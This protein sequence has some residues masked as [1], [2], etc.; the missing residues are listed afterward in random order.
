MTYQY[1]Y[2]VIIPHKNRQQ[3]LKRCLDSIPRR[4]NVQIIVVDDKSDPEK[5]DFQHFP[6]LHEKNTEVYFTK[7]GKG[8]GYARNV[9]LDH[10]K[11]KWILFADSDDQYL[12]NLEEEMYNY[13]ESEA[14]M[15]VFRQKRKNADGID[16]EC[17]YDN[18]FD[19]AA[20]GNFDSL[21]SYSCVYG[22]FIKK[23]FLDKYHIRFQEVMYS[24]DVLFS[25]KVS[26]FSNNILFVNKHIYC[27]YES[28][29]SLMR[30]TNWKNPYIR[31]KVG[32]DAF[33]F[34][35]SI[36]IISHKSDPENDWFY[37]MIWWKKTIKVKPL[38]ALLLVPRIYCTIG[39]AFP[40]Y[41]VKVCF[42]RLFS[43]FSMETK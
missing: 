24:N 19:E 41:M 14:D 26:H 20:K 40:I 4:E 12:D 36:G 9:G 17:Q 8:A 43:L 29:H 25:L 28:L 27:V 23:D 1:N 15:I 35:K 34:L 39:N 31:T 37:W 30:N 3:L 7:E 18:M 5:V 2:T 6:G 21:K 11:G 33:T 13:V 38:A 16:I 32:L 10:A 22:R 42:N